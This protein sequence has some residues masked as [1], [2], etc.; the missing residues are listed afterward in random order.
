M[1]STNTGAIFNVEEATGKERAMLETTAAQARLDAPNLATAEKIDANAEKE[2]QAAVEA[3]HL[4]QK[5]TA[6]P[7]GQTA[8]SP[9]INASIPS[10][11]DS[12]VNAETASGKGRS[13]I[14]TTA[15]Q[16]VHQAPDFTSAFQ[17]EHNARR[18]QEAAKQ[19]AATAKTM[20]RKMTGEPSTAAAEYHSPTDAA[21]AEGKRDVEQAKAVGAGYVEQAK[22]MVSSTVEAAQ[23]FVSGSIQ[24]PADRELATGTGTTTGTGKTV[25]E[26]GADT[27]A[28]L[29]VMAENAL[30][31]AQPVVQSAYTTVVETAQPVVSSATQSTKEYIASAKATGLESPP[32][33]TNL[34]AASEHN[35]P[36][37]TAPLQTGSAVVDTPYDRAATQPTPQN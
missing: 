11:T 13:E 6:Q 17:A 36:S 34:K 19:A 23:S 21:V 8:G 37:K 29:Q 25:T 30:K 4:A 12:F 14:E 20:G 31:A 7:A 18:E 32:T 22:Q 28:S 26:V 35:I 1:S 33:D 9:T 16:A 3:A 2:H 24:N 10:A 27:F 5:F 15:A